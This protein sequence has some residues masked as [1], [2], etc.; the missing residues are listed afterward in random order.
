[1]AIVTCATSKI[2]RIFKIA[3]LLAIFLGVQ[4]RETAAGV[5]T[6]GFRPPAVPLAVVDPYFRYVLNT[7]V[8]LELECIIL[9]RVGVV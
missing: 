1:M 2:P 5:I 6:P 9:S 4:P 3:I 8:M 7:G